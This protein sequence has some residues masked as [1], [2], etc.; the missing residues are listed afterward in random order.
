MK[1]K[2]CIALVV[3]VLSIFMI[4]STLYAELLDIPLF[5][6]KKS[7][8]CWATSTGAILIYYKIDGFTADNTQEKILQHVK[9]SL[10]NKGGTSQEM[11]KALKMGKTNP[12]HTNTYS[13][14]NLIADC[15]RQNP[16]MVNVKWNSS[17]AH[18][19]TYSGF[20]EGR[21]GEATKHRIMNPL[22]VNKGRYEY[23]TYQSLKKWGGKGTWNYSITTKFDMKPFITISTP[24]GSEKWEQNSTQ[25][26]TWSD[27]VSGKVNIELLEN[28]TVSKVLAQ[29]VESNGS[30]TWKID[31]NVKIGDAYKVRIS[32][33]DNGTI[34]A[35]SA[36]TFSIVKGITSIVGSEQ[37]SRSRYT[38]RVE[39]S[40]IHY[41]IPVQDNASVVTITLF[42]V[43]G[44]LIKTLVNEMKRPGHYSID[45]RLVDN[46]LA[47]G[48]L[49]GKMWTEN[50]RTSFKLIQ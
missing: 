4:Q 46:V 20:Q 24:K 22:P 17:G 9:G 2:K 19:T 38:I 18:A 23:F 49:I 25:T 12:K 1:N 34:K 41:Q 28:N 35:E 11:Q 5:G 48:M 44:K 42:D 26:I 7:S 21:N 13:E 14:E 15:N 6:Q 31:G 43:H 47:S 29:S 33:T 37:L 30:W 27:N 40:F 3:F 36:G 10:V 50:F 39:N 32:S 16:L 45:L 8:W